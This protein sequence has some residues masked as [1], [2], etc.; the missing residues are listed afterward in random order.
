MKD[1]E[2]IK[3]IVQQVIE[4]LSSHEKERKQ[5]P[6]LLLAGETS[7]EENNY[8][9]YLHK[10][11]SVAH[12]NDKEPIDL[13]GI[14]RVLF[15]QGSQ[16]LIAKG[17]LGIEDSPESKL[18]SRC[19]WEEVPVTIIPTLYLQE[20]LF[21]KEVR[22]RTY[23]SKILK[24]TK[25]LAEYGVEMETLDSF[26]GKDAAIPHKV[27]DHGGKTLITQRD[28]QNIKEKEIVIGQN[29][30]ITP[31]ARDTALELGIKLN[32]SINQGGI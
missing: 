18:M 8:L 11:W 16:D 13:K 17:A 23:R 26:A 28:I 22:N 25:I 21:K 20:H 19:I 32:Y 31:L 14:T 15:L 9:S 29:T 24:Y 6:T 2:V 27:T 10:K 1:S 5:K 4:V 7:F 30:I 3:Q 12:F